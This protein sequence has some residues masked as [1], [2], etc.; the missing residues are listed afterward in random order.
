[1]CPLIQSVREELTMLTKTPIYEPVK[2]YHKLFK[3][4]CRLAA[5]ITLAYGLWWLYGVWMYD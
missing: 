1:M 5:L 2:S 3:R 4:I